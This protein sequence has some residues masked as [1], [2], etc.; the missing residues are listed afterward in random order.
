MCGTCP[1]G[2]TSSADCCDASSVDA[3]LD[4]PFVC[5]PVKQTGCSAGACYSAVQGTD[6]MYTCAA[7]GTGTNAANCTQST[8]C[9]AG[10]W[11]AQP[12]PNKCTRYCTTDAQCTDPSSPKCVG[13]ESGQPWG[14]CACI[15]SDPAGIG[16][17][18]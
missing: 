16:T 1:D 12:G 3:A 6:F 8:D 17:C 15:T 10:Y 13:N 2:G 11:C 18:P 9:A 4:A 7:S 5:D 14:Y